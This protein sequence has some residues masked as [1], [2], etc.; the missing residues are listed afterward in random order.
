MP[1]RTA[2]NT[3]K[4]VRFQ[5]EFCGIELKQDPTQAFLAAYGQT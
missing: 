1:G 5:F 2:C 4:K 3:R